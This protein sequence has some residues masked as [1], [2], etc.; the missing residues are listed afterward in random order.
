MLAHLKNRHCL[1]LN[2]KI[3]DWW[4][5]DWTLVLVVVRMTWLSVG[6]SGSPPPPSYQTWACLSQCTLKQIRVAIWTKE[7]PKCQFVIRS[8]IW[9]PSSQDSHLIYSVFL[10]QMQLVYNKH[11]MI[12]GISFL[13]SLDFR[14]LF[15]IESQIA[16][17]SSSQCSVECENDA[18]LWLWA[19]RKRITMITTMMMMK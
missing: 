2:P 11:S 16:N 9:T 10:E 14:F 8:E 3:A 12:Y 17:Y 15:V 7:N 6:R 18:S 5:L 19:T 13:V 1:N 4:W